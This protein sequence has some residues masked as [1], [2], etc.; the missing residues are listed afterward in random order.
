MFWSTGRT[1]HQLKGRSCS[2]TT[3]VLLLLQ[4][5]ARVVLTLERLVSCFKEDIWWVIL[6][7][8][9]SWVVLHQQRLVSCAC[10]MKA[11]S[12]VVLGWLRTT[13]E[14]FLFDDKQLVS[15]S[16][17]I[18]N[19]SGRLCLNKNNTWVVL[20]WLR[21]MRELFLFDSKRL[22]SG[23]CLMQND[24]WVVLVWLRTTS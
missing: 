20:V 5:T 23:S 11:H 19:D 10:L 21:T 4:N 16:C 15:H 9:D 18:Q 12:S 8:K 6:R 3:H 1:I 13:P 2:K 7:R 24:S 22:V 14:S 17:L